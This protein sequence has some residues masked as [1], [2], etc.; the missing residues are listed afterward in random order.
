LINNHGFLNN[1]LFSKVISIPKESD[2]PGDPRDPGD[3]EDPGDPEDFKV[4]GNL[5]MHLD[6]FKI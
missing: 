4:P 5:T 1:S 6:G 2:D 3:L